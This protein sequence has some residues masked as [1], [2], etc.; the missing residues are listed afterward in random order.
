MGTDNTPTTVSKNID[1]LNTILNTNVTLQELLA[2]YI[3]R[4]MS[5]SMDISGIDIFQNYNCNFS[6]PDKLPSLKSVYAVISNFMNKY[7]YLI[8][9]LNINVKKDTHMTSTNVLQYA[10]RYANYAPDLELSPELSN[11]IALG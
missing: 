8:E 5:F 1:K 6:I 7:S 4:S 11:M 2:V 9:K 3:M 10:L